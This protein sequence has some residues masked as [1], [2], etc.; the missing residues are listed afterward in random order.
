M[1]HYVYVLG[2]IFGEDGSTEGVLEAFDFSLFP[3]HH[4]VLIN[5][6]IFMYILSHS[7]IHI[8]LSHFKII[9]SFFIQKVTSKTLKRNWLNYRL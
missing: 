7:K 9:D 6:I 3:S 1:L 4:N 8:S 2:A 5:M